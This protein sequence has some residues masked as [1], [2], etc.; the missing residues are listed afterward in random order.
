M[1]VHLIFDLR[2]KQFSLSVISTLYGMAG[3]RRI[4]INI[5][6]D[7]V[8]I[9]DYIANDKEAMYSIHGYYKSSAYFN[10]KMYDEML[11]ECDEAIKINE[12]GFDALYNKGLALHNLGKYQEAIEWFDKALKINPNYVDALITQRCSS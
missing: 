10:L 9:P 8:R 6:N 7:V 4:A 12:N 11:F 2:D 5:V 1:H 3:E